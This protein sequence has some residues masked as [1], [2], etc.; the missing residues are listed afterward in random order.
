MTQGLL[1]Q[2]FPETKVQIELAMEY[3][4]EEVRVYPSVRRRKGYGCGGRGDGQEPK[5]NVVI[6]FLLSLHL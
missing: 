2:Y 5:V 6:L 4:V 1:E 3:Q